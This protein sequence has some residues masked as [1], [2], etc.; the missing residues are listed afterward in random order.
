MNYLNHSA[1]EIAALESFQNYYLYQEEEAKQF[2]EN[3][4]NQNPQKQG[5]ITTAMR[6]LDVLKNPVSNTEIQS[7]FDRLKSKIDT[8]P[9]LAPKIQFTRRTLFKWASA[10]AAAVLLFF[11]VNFFL[12][13]QP[14]VV[15]STVDTSFGEIKEIKLPDGSNV[16]LNSNS[17]LKY[18][19]NWTNQSIREVWLEGEAFFDIRKKPLKGAAQFVVH[20]DDT[21]VKV[22]GTTFNVYNREHKVA[23]V[24]ET[25]KVAIDYN[26][27]GKQKTQQ[28]LPNDAFEINAG[29]QVD[30]QQGINTELHTAWKDNKLVL[31]DTPLKKVVDILEENFGFEV[32]VKNQ[33]VLERKLTATIPIIDIN[34]LLDGLREIYGLKIKKE[35][36]KITIQ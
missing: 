21:N 20:S 31:D 29:D 4:I 16:Y 36:N 7:E 32:S 30:F 24:L 25:G 19:S 23:V 13:P 34:I 15:L 26:Q 3:W 27:N 2:W 28:M 11:A 33:Q 9:Q 10:A 35:E 6:L 22:L 8:E 1:E 14:N 12:S 18:D 17:S 5:D